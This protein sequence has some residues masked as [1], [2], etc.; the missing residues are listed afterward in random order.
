MISK[1]M[2]TLNSNLR[3]KTGI[4]TLHL[5]PHLEISADNGIPIHKA[6]SRVIWPFLPKAELI[7]FVLAHANSCSRYSHGG[8]ISIFFQALHQHENPYH[9][10]IPL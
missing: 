10:Q 8:G 1:H 5:N 3:I 2:S 9:S 6:S 4:S 7:V